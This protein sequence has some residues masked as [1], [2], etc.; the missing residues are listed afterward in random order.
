[1]LISNKDLII[2]GFPED[3][4]E[5]LKTFPVSPKAVIVENGVETQIAPI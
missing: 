1:M 2:K 4:E 5:S 3:E